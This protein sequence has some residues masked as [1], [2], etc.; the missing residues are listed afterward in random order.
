MITFTDLQSEY[1]ECKT[2]IDQAIK[3]CLENN[4]FITGPDV[5]EFEKYLLN[6]QVQK[7]VV[8]VVLALL[9]YK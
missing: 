3:H 9:H 6:I 5:T 4:S 1:Q 8:H 7:V 2:E